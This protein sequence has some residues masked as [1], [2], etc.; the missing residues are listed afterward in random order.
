MGQGWGCS[1]KGKKGGKSEEK[2]G[3][4]TLPMRYAL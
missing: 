3:H 1:E 4:I 2:V